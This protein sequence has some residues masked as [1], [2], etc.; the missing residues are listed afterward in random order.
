MGWK[1][2]QAVIDAARG[3]KTGG[4]MEGLAAEA[5]A[6]AAEEKKKLSGGGFEGRLEALKKGEEYGSEVYEREIG[7]DSFWQDRERRLY[8]LGQQGL[9]APEMQKIQQGF[10]EVSRQGMTGARTAGARGSMAG[11]AL[12]SAKTA[13]EARQLAMDAQTKLHYAEEAEKA[14]MARRLLKLGLGTAY[15]QMSSGVDSSERMQNI[16]G[17]QQQNQGFLSSLF[18]K[19]L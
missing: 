4:G 14:Y 12:A 7:R 16:A 5:D 1:P 15:G 3:K 9:A 11:Q 8:Q 17:E 18:G 6:V 19:I 10:K 2:G 13:N